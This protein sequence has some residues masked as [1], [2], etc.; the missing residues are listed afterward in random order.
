MSKES[1]TKEQLIDRIQ[2]LY[3]TNTGDFRRKVSLYLNRFAESQI[4]PKTKKYIQS[5][6]NK[7]LYKELPSDSEMENIES[8]RFELLNQLKK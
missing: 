2:S 3:E 1:L 6:K 5:L 8:L 7:V 4:E